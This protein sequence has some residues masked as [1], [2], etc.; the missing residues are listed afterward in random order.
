MR[1][2]MPTSRGFTLVEVLVAL[3]VSASFLALV[4]QGMQLGF[5]YYERIQQGSHS[6]E[7]VFLMRRYLK[8]RIELMQPLTEE[9]RNQL[10]LVFDGGPQRIR[11]VSVTDAETFREL[12]WVDLSARGT[13]PD[14]RVVLALWPYRPGDR[15]GGAV[16]NAAEVI[17]VAAPASLNIRYR[18]PSVRNDAVGGFGQSDGRWRANWRD[19]LVLPGLVEV[20]LETADGAWAP[21]IAR[22]DLQ[23]FE[24]GGDG[25]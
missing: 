20:S 25:F 8:Q 15:L 18:P 22:P 21:L 12:T 5:A 11:F 14:Q 24:V 10:A 2:L 4:Y 19:R 7:N 1:A 3:M 13:A 17:E 23:S 9:R 6:S 16:P